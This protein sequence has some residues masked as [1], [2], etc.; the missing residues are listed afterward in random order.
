MA[1]LEYSPL[2]ASVVSKIKGAVQEAQENAQPTPSPAEMKAQEKQIE[3]QADQQMGQ[4]RLQ[5]KQAEDAVNLRHEQAMSEIKLRDAARQR[6]M[7]AYWKHVDRVN[8]AKV[9]AKER[10]VEAAQQRN[11]RDEEARVTGEASAKSLEPVVAS[12]RD[13]F[14]P[15]NEGLM[16][17]IANLAKSHAAGMSAL[18][19]EIRRPRKRTLVRGKDGRATGAIEE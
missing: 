18:H 11:Q 1:M 8:E 19:A 15:I 4:Q 2:P 6:Q 16:R 17:E 10:D 7:D 13:S 12:L 5:A 3:I 9:R 14:S